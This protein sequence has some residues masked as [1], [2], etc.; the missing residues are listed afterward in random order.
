[1]LEVKAMQQ[2]KEHEIRL[3]FLEEATE[4]LNTI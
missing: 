3:Q 4:Y 2:D 1:M